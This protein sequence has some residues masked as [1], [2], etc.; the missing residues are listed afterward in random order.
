MSSSVS[1]ISSAKPIFD[2]DS[3]LHTIIAVCSLRSLQCTYLKGVIH[4]DFKSNTEF[5]NYTI[6]K[7]NLNCIEFLDFHYCLCVSG[8]LSWA[9]I[10]LVLI[11]MRSQFQF[12]L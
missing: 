4:C 9:Y 8:I 10:Y 11:F 5:L 6:L 7:W 2:E 1:Y 3:R 12:S